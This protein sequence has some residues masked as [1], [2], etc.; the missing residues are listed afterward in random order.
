[1]V[2]QTFFGAVWALVGFAA[3]G[4]A[5]QRGDGSGSTDGMGGS[6]SSTGGSFGSGGMPLVTGS[7]GAQ[8]F[9]SSGGAQPFTGSGGAQP[10]T[11]SG[12]AVAALG[13]QSA[14]GKAAS[15][16]MPF[17]SAGAAGE[18]A[19]EGNYIACGCG[20]CGGGPTEATACYYPEYGIRLSDAIQ[21]DALARSQPGCANAGCSLGANYACCMSAPQ[22]PSTMSLYAYDFLPDEPRLTLIKT[23]GSGM[24]ATLVLSGLGAALPTLSADVLR[25][26]GVGSY[27][28]CMPGARRSNAI[29]ISGSVYE[30]NDV[31]G[32]LLNVHVT[33]FIAAENGE[34]TPVRFDVDNLNPGLKCPLK[35]GALRPGHPPDG[36]SLNAVLAQAPVKGAARDPRQFCS[37]DAIP[38]AGTQRL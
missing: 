38:V 22:E 2:K 32:C 1:M 20:C 13:G 23:E 15:G 26:T 34:V 33:L 24:C 11:G 36:A 16:G 25:W 7:G 6:A 29:G 30:R 5:A 19:C 21:Q 12:G 14:G 8:P 27:T 28:P 3:C 37:L 10:F 35:V 18:P 4:G 31:D 17:E 9:T